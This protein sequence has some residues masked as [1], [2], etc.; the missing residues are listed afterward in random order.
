MTFMY[1]Q[2]SSKTHFY[3]SNPIIKRIMVQIVFLPFSIHLRQSPILNMLP[4]HP[5]HPRF[6]HFFLFPFLPPACFPPLSR[7]FSRER[8]GQGVSAPVSFACRLLQMTRIFCLHS[9]ITVFST[10]HRAER[11][12][13]YPCAS[14]S[15]FLPAFPLFPASFRGR[16]GDRG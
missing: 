14:S 15:C 10:Y 11:S 7:V 6:R 1:P 4:F 2:K 12:K 5:A 3:Q 8:G 9:R 16:E 13:P